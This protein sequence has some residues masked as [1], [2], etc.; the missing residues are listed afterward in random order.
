MLSLTPTLGSSNQWSPIWWK[1]CRHESKIV[2]KTQIR[3]V[4]RRKR[5]RW[6]LLLLCKHMPGTHRSMSGSA[7]IS[8]LDLL[9]GTKPAVRP[10]LQDRK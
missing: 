5:A 8:H 2:P 4:P 6:E 10:C 1:K 7:D 3:A 9:P